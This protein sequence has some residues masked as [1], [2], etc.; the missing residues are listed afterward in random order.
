[1][2]HILPNLRIEA[3]MVKKPCLM[4]CEFCMPSFCHALQLKRIGSLHSQALP[5]HGLYAVP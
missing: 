3:H 2:L 4:G 1:M 5:H